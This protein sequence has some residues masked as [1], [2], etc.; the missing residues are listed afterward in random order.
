MRAIPLRPLSLSSVVR[1]VESL[2]TSLAQ[3]EDAFE[4]I[5]WPMARRGEARCESVEDELAWLLRGLEEN[6]RRVT[7]ARHWGWDGQGGVAYKDSGAVARLSLPAMRQ[8]ARAVALDL[9]LEPPATPWIDRATRLIEELV[10]CGAERA[11]GALQEAGLVRRPF[12]IEGLLSAAL[13][14]GR[15]VAELDT[16]LPRRLVPPGA[17]GWLTR[18]QKIL[19]RRVGESGLCPVG[20]LLAPRWPAVDLDVA[21]D[22]LGM[23]EGVR[24]LTDDAVTLTTVE[25]PGTFVGY[26]RRVLTVARSL[27]LEALHSALVGRGARRSGPD[28]R[29]NADQ[30]AAVCQEIGGVAV[31]GRT[32]SVGP[33]FVDADL[34]PLDRQVVEVVR[35]AGGRVMPA[36]LS[37]RLQALGLS[38]M[39]ASWCCRHPLLVATSLGLALVGTEGGRPVDP[40]VAPRAGRKLA[41]AE[42]IAAAQELNARD[43]K[44]SLASESSS[45]AESA[46]GGQSNRSLGLRLQQ[47]RQER[48]VSIADVARALG[49]TLDVVRSW[50]AGATGPLG[51]LRTRT[52][53]LLSRSGLPTRAAWGTK[54][55]W[56]ATVLLAVEDA[57]RETLVAA[58]SSPAPAALGLAPP[59]TPCAAVEDELAWILTVAPSERAV[60]ALS[61]HWGW[62]GRG[63]TTGTAGGQE[64][65]ISHERVRQLAR[66][67]LVNV[68]RSPLPTPFLERAWELV[69]GCVPCTAQEVEEALEREGLTRGRFR[70]E[71]LLVAALVLGR[72]VPA[73]LFGD[74]GARLLLDPAWDPRWPAAIRAAVAQLERRHGFATVDGVQRLLREGRGAV[75]ER[76]LRLFAQELVGVRWLG[77]EAPDGLVVYPAMQGCK[78]WQRAWKALTM[79]GQIDVD[80]LHRSMVQCVRPIDSPVSSDVLLALA[81]RWPGVVV[82]GRVLKAGASFQPMALEATDR[83]L[84]EVLGSRTAVPRAELA[85]AF[86]RAGLA[87]E[88]LTWATNGHALVV[89]TG[90]GY[91]LRGRAPG[92]DAPRKHGPSG[93]VGV[94]LAELQ[95]WVAQQGASLK[96]IARHLRVRP[97]TLRQWLAG[98]A[99]P[100]RVTC[101][102]VRAVINGVSIPPGSPRRAPWQL[103]SREELEAY[104]VREGLS[105]TGLARRI[106]VSDNKVW[107][108]SKEGR[109]PSLETQHKIRALLDGPLSTS[110]SASE[111]ADVPGSPS[112]QE[113]ILDLLLASMATGRR[114]MP[115]E[116][117]AL[118]RGMKEALG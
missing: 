9:R 63:G 38:G 64:A 84:L 78:R 53:A 109:S 71:G 65:G 30:L 25:G 91:S 43:A 99:A 66:A 70:V 55:S 88:T 73:V 106:G 113:K 16:A 56:L 101:Q 3:V 29:P 67:T 79:L 4:R 76:V 50:E 21:R 41:P 98:R 20:V 32:V 81:R 5:P 62:D 40:L 85:S 7:L 58:L 14:L 96:A 72:S 118:I 95:A 100:R 22:L 1:L 104:R 90:D 103:V 86:Q 102:R 68:N 60:V 61:R 93:W 39:S 15:S 74:E 69:R 116:L 36:E 83:V 44:D 111:I 110:R 48:G 75:P 112:E 12:R 94:S 27:S 17:V 108:W 80:D 10:P 8:A 19:R 87:T 47:W 51:S 26:V 117:P 92:R 42:L 114:V 6:R 59:A 57:R 2:P 33:G 105:K 97:A 46:R 34:S 13:L 82:E 35:A 54:G 49:T 28:P 89:W 23:V 31:K 45:T 52:F 37:E 24:F 77:P 115:S 107:E 11:E 18:A